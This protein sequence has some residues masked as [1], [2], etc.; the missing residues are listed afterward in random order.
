[1]VD[2]K[3]PP[4]I[5][6]VLFAYNQERYIRHAVEAALAQDYPNLEVIVSD[7]CSTDSTFSVMQE[8]LS[9]YQGPHKIVVRQTRTN[10]GSLLHLA[11]VVRIARGEFLVLAA[12]DDISKANR[13]TALQ[14]AWA[15]TGAWGICSQYDRVD[16][17]GKVLEQ[18]VVA[19]VLAGEGLKCYF[20]KADGPVPIVHGCTSAYD[21]RV[22]DYLLLNSQDYILAED[23]ALT[24]L[25]NLLGKRIVYLDQSLVMYR[26][27]DGSLTNSRK[28]R[29][30]ALAEIVQD[31]DRIERL[32]RA[33]ANR[34]RLFLRMDKYLGSHQVR[35]LLVDIVRKELVIQEAKANWW[36]RSFKRKV[37]F[38]AVHPAATWALARMFGRR[39]F[40]ISK[41][42]FRR[43]AFSV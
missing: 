39:A 27:C 8:L 1:M 2:D 5:T 19:P 20:D 24:I 12:G 26:E 16:E 13:V 3:L 29:R 38:I 33:Q 42:A 40:L 31:E 41:W 11:S 25:I 21:R 37:A 32:A 7:D 22:F 15:S 43:V 35:R 10:C 23:G 17:G 28:K 30:P 6:F 4:L 18:S 34:C 9:S 14:E 36:Q